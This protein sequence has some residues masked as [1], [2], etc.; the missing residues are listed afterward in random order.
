MSLA[1]QEFLNGADREDDIAE[2]RGWKL[3]LLLVVE[4][5]TVRSDPQT[6]TPEQ[7][8]FILSRRVGTFFVA[9]RKMWDSC[10]QGISTEAED[11]L[12]PQNAQLKGPSVW[13]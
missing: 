12:T 3:F 13:F 1:L 9:V 7:I 2:C 10:F 5:T 4:T 6:T 8:Q 11:I